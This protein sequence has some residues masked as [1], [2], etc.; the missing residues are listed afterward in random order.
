MLVIQVDGVDTQ[1]LE[2][3]L[4]GRAHVF[5]AP[6]DAAHGGVVGVAH[7]TELGGKEDLLAPLPDRLAYQHLVGVRAVHVGG[8]EQGQAAL[9]CA[10]EGGDRFGIVAV[11][12][13]RVVEV[14]HAHAAKAKGGN[15]RAVV[16]QGACLHG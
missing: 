12:V 5:G 13:A 11:G 7:D 8:I 14:A 2:A 4:A 3:G 10:M 1:P 9:E 15:L 16:A 6:A